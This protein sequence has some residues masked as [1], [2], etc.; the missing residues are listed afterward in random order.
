MRQG[1]FARAAVA[2]VVGLLFASRVRPRTRRRSAFSDL[3]IEAGRVGGTLT[4]HDLDAGH[5]LALGDASALL[6]PATARRYAP[7]LADILARRLRLGSTAV[8]SPSHCRT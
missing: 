7:A 8:R 3:R 6:D 4:V 2:T 1:R 5:E